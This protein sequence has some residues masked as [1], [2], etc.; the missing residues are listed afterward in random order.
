[1]IHSY[2]IKTKQLHFCHGMLLSSFL[3]KNSIILTALVHCLLACLPEPK[4][5]NSRIR[6]LIM[7]YGSTYNYGSTYI[8]G[9]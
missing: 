1:M 7:I 6:M 8:R 9:V 3:C 2:L 5:L 4:A